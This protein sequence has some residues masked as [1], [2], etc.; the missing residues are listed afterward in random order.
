MAR[1]N[2]GWQISEFGWNGIKGVYCVCSRDNGKT[3]I[4]YIG[5]A[6]DIG[7]RVLSTN[8]PYRNLYDE[9]LTFIKYRETERYVE[10]EKQMIKKLKPR[11]NIQHTK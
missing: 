11:L 1:K 7:K 3:I 4:H 10:L 2:K 6:K 9:H 8:H 5:S